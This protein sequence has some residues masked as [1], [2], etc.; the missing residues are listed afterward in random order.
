MDSPGSADRARQEGQRQG[1][2]GASLQGE[3]KEGPVRPRAP[4]RRGAEG[5]ASW[6]PEGHLSK[7]QRWLGERDLEDVATGKGT[8]ALLGGN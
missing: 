4:V 6:S 2:G 8:E 7:A 5:G 1:V 3:E